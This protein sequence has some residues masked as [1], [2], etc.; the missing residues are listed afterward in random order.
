M[1]ASKKYKGSVTVEAAA[2][3]PV[4]LIAM[5]ALVSVNLMMNFQILLQKA[6]YE[7]AHKLSLECSDGHNEAISTVKEDIVS[8]LKESGINDYILEGGLNG[9][10]F[11]DTRLDDP[12]YAE[13][14]AEYVFKPFGSDFLGLICIPMTQK[15]VMHVWCGYEHGY[16]GEDIGEYVYITSDSEVY[17]RNRECSHIKLS[18]VKVTGS[19]DD[20][21]NDNGGKY[22]SCQFCRSSK[23]DSPLYVTTEGSRYHNS[24]SCTGLKRKVIAVKL[25]N[26]KD[27]R[28]C[29]RCGREY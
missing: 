20:L 18:I 6:L 29:S 26:I 9:I 15:A 4:F 10:E 14:V 28:P 5:L 11:K 24:I 23:N 13:I 16:F 1:N 8:M 17:H 21:R 3:L 7:E 12:E 25:G 19:V 27:K 22:H 2:I